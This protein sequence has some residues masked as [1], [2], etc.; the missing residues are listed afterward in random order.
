M[1]RPIFEAGSGA[2]GI[3]LIAGIVAAFVVRGWA[4]KRQA[5]TGQ[6]F[7]VA[8]TMA[9]LILGLPILA[10]F[11]SGM[12]VSFDYAQ[13]GRFNLSGGMTLIPEFVALTLASSPTRRPSSAR[14]CEPASRR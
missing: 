4:R 7:P 14:S 5:A 8:A 2:I 1:P 9:G 10:Y 3:A 11:L 13:Q 6:Q 12:P